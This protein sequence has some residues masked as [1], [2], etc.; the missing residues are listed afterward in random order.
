MYV[1]LNEQHNVTGRT[2]LHE[3]VM[4]NNVATVRKLLEA[5]ALP[6]VGHLSQVCFVGEGCVCES[7]CL[8]ACFLSVDAGARGGCAA[9][10]WPLITGVF[11]G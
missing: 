4:L 6:D 9:R 5:G 11:G 3:A 10:N 8:C 1:G 7:V 2:P